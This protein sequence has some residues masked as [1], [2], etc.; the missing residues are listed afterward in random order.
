M[1]C[2]NGD[3]Y[4]RHTTL[5]FIS[6]IMNLPQFRCP[7]CWYRGK[8]ESDVNHHVSN[9][10]QC[11]VKALASLRAPLSRK[12]LASM[13]KVFKGPPPCPA[14]KPKIPRGATPNKQP[15]VPDINVPEWNLE[16]LQYLDWAADDDDSKDGMF[17]TFHIP[18]TPAAPDIAENGNVEDLNHRQSNVADKQPAPKRSAEEGKTKKPTVEDAKDIGDADMASGA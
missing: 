18:N 13:P 12:W 4:K 3:K 9:S 2:S 14:A 6:T 10:K 11:K 1:L 17:T 5:A 15:E 16:N 8:R 7:Y